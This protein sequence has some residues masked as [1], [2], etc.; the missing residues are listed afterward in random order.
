MTGAT[1]SFR[2]VEPFTAFRE[3]G[4]DNEIGAGRAFGFGQIDLRRG[5]R[6]SANWRWVETDS[7][8]MVA[9]PVPADP[10][11]IHHFVKRQG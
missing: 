6:S 11:S 10:G 2:G 4:R 9:T 8:I 5:A 3:N 1:P 7:G